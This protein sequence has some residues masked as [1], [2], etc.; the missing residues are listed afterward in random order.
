MYKIESLNEKP[1]KVLT[2]EPNI[3]NTSLIKNSF[4]GDYVEIGVNNN[5]QESSIDSY[6]YTSE[7]CQIIFSTIK[8]FVNIAS[9]VR[10]N[11][12]QHPMYWANQ[13]HIQYRQEMYGFGSDDKDFF[14]WRREKKVVIGNDVWLGHNVVV[15]GN[16]TIGD[17]AVIG[18]SSVVTKDIPPFAIA[19]GNPAR[20]IKYRFDEQKIKD[21]LDIAWWD[22]DE[23]KIKLN[24]DDFKNIDK[25]IEKYKK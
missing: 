9:Y 18:S 16:V 14:N 20:V 2:K 11:P 13:H 12:S 5:I 23:D 8:K 19:V 25:F 6:S 22:W 17:G 1:K 15:M 24:I 10:L 3:D 7:N 4:F 21:L